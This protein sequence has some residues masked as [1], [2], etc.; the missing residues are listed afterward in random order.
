MIGMEMAQKT[1]ISHSPVLALV[2]PTASGKTFLSMILA[3]KLDGEIISADSRQIYKYLSIGTAKPSRGDLLKVPHHFIDILNPEQPYNAA[4]F[5]EQARL[6]IEELLK[7]GKRP[8]VVGGSGLYVRA[9][10][11]G[12]F[13][14]PGK[15]P[16]IREQLEGE[17]KR[18]GPDTL[19]EKL[20][21]VDPVAAAKMDATKVRRVIRALEVYYTIGKP[22][23]DLYS[24]QET[25]STFDVV[26][27]GLLWERT[28]LYDHINRRVDAMIEKGLVDEVRSLCARGYTSGMNALNTVGYKETLD[29]IAGKITKEEMINRIK[30]NTRR[31]AK[32]QMTWFRADKRIRWI[33]V[34][35][36]SDWNKIA[37]TIQKDLAVT[38]KN[39]SSQN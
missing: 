4:E 36:D 14:G 13:E 16:E 28:V 8:I 1:S 10:I 21:Q 25:K 33:P 15:N 38:S 6:K 12:F 20:K 17:A 37:E 7:C 18:L 27:Y 11:D 3:K 39:L 9:V 22:I 34:S 29:F 30:Q 5:G 26:Q 19:F 32:R 24:I 31:F 2:G 35:E 23:S